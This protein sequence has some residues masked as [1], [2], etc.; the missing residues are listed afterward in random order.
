MVKVRGA[1]AVSVTT[2]PVF[3]AIFP[4]VVE[5][6]AADA[7]SKTFLAVSSFCS[8]VAETFELEAV[9]SQIPVVPKKNPLAS[10][11]PDTTFSVSA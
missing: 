1:E 8:E 4:S 7:R 10:V 2:A 11:E 6:V 3:Q 9:A 5:V